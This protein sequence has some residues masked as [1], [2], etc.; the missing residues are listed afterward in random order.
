MMVDCGKNLGGM[1][2]INN[3]YF[4][5]IFIVQYFKNILYNF[6]IL[7]CAKMYV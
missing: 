6:I 1:K 3:I 4:G 5:S 7:F 2:N